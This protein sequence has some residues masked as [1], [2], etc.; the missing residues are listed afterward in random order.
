MNIGEEYNE[1]YTYRYASVTNS[2]DTVWCKASND[3]DRDMCH[4]MIKNIQAI[5]ETCSSKANYKKVVYPTFHRSVSETGKESFN[6]RDNDLSKWFNKRTPIL[7]KA[8]SKN[9]QKQSTQT[10]A[11]ALAGIVAKF[12]DILQDIDVNPRS[13]KITPS[14]QQLKLLNSVS[15]S[16]L[17]WFEKTNNNEDEPPLTH[18]AYHNDTFRDFRAKQIDKILDFAKSI[19]INLVDTNAPKEHFKDI[20]MNSSGLFE[21]KTKTEQE[22]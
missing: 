18:D 4:T 15:D 5:V 3:D 20:Q 14:E 6:K 13:R 2:A 1:A 10:P 12:N 8:P 11:E 17:Y 9:Y 7:A 22:E 21:V 19:E 16:L